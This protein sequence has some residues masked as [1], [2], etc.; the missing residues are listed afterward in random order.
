MDAE[1]DEAEGDAPEAS[2]PTS[3]VNIETKLDSDM[4]ELWGEK[5]AGGSRNPEDIVEYF[6]SLS[7]EHRAMLAKRL[8]D[9]VFRIAKIKDA[10]VVANGWTRALE[11]GVATTE[12]LRKG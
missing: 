12:V 1:E 11:E 9:D 2:G 8:V 7:E 3:G 6:R 5:D 10:Q 4:K